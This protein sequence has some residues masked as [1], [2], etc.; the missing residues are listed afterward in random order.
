MVKSA[1]PLVRT[2][3]AGDEATSEIAVPIRI[4]DTMAGVLEIPAV[5]G[6]GT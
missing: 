4:G 5:V 2:P 6:L 3:G 1:E